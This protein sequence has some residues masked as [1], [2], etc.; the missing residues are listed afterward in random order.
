[1]QGTYAVRPQGS[2][3]S[4]PH[5]HG[6][7]GGIGVQMPMNPGQ[8][9]V[10]AQRPVAMPQAQR[11]VTY[12]THPMSMS[13]PSGQG[14]AAWAASQ[15]QPQHMSFAGSMSAPVVVHHVAPPMEEYFARE[16][17]SPRPE[18]DN[19]D[20]EFLRLLDSL[21]V[22]VDLMA[23]MQHTRAS[24]AHGVEVRRLG[25]KIL[26]R[27]RVGPP[28]FDLR[29]LLREDLLGMLVTLSGVV[30]FAI[31]QGKPPAEVTETR[32]LYFMTSTPAIVW[33][34]LMGLCLFLAVI[35]MA[36]DRCE[37]VR[38]CLLRRR[39]GRHPFLRRKE[40]VEAGITGVASAAAPSPAA[41]LRLEMP[42]PHDPG[43]Q[44]SAADDS[45]FGSTSDEESNDEEPD[46]TKEVWR[47]PG[48]A[49]CRHDL[50]ELM[51]VC[52]LT[53]CSSAA[54]DL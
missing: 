53:S 27:S 10:Y 20:A 46:L 7:S 39:L 51:A 1:M 17:H 25:G 28:V 41:S 35:Y 18:Q 45:Y 32:F 48:R 15:M 54:M 50:L 23:Q 8:P 34:A 43:S 16:D 44:N 13:A 12:M 30:C 5:M 42:T 9:M 21:E 2:F 3:V 36:P 52:I 26:R 33:N 38:S 37:G 19:Q 6:N 31:F 29:P 49:G 11:P 4:R 14:Q 24:H 47:N 22:R 40:G